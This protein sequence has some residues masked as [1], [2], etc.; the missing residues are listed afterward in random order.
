MEK[1]HDQR[2]ARTTIKNVA[3]DAGVSVAAVSKVLRNA[4]GVSDALRAKV[5]STIERLGYRPSTAARGMRGRTFT[6]GVLLVEI[7]NPFVPQIIDGINE[8]LADSNYRALIGV[9]QSMA[10]LEAAL[11][12]SM[13]SYHMDGLIL[14]APQ[15]PG[16]ELARY[17]KQIP[18]VV[19]GHHE[20]TATAFDTVNSDDQEGAALVVRTFL[21]SGH[22]DIG[23]LSLV[24]DD[25]LSTNVVSQR[26][27]GFRKAMQRAGLS[28]DEKISR[29][30][31]DAQLHR[32]EVATFLKSDKR[33]RALF[34]WSD[35][36]AVHVL[37]SAKRLDLRVPEDLSVIGYDNSSPAALA[38]IDLSS[39]DQSGHRL[40]SLASENL[41]S[42][43]GGRNIASHILIE[44]TL[45]AR[46]THLVGLSADGRTRVS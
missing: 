4:Y 18:M 8:V 36:D 39:I 26:E 40:G 29:L 6:I 12:E 23:M 30:S 33:P 27:I 14:L 34:C 5:Q 22:R 44:P 41:L 9:G 11:L 25:P 42:R 28:S 7:A 24:T 16:A 21:Q 46:Q 10:T 31:F 20:A 19:I 43:I 38:S 13:I 2:P 17:A 45:I 37:D 1:A 15:L 3:K 32:N 35:L